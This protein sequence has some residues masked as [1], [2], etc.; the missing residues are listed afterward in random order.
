MK[1]GIRD[2]ASEIYKA[3]GKVFDTPPEEIEYA[4]GIVGTWDQLF[5]TILSTKEMG[6]P[7]KCALCEKEMD[8]F[9]TEH[10]EILDEIDPKHIN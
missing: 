7:L 5:A 10:P 3:I 4:L 9:L 8:E 2:Y 6:L 1:K